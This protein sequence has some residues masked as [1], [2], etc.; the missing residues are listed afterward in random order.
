MNSLHCN[1]AGIVVSLSLDTPRGVGG[2]AEAVTNEGEGEQEAGMEGDKENVRKGETKEEGNETEEKAIEEGDN[3][4]QTVIVIVTV[5][6]IM[7]LRNAVA[8]FVVIR[9]K[10]RRRQ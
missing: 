7:Q 10:Q 9:K 5:I 4:K 8:P 1:D 2:K 6:I 3:K